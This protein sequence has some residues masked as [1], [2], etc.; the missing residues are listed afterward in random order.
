MMILY[1]QML[2]FIHIGGEGGVARCATSNMIYNHGYNPGE[3]LYKSM[4]SKRFNTIKRKIIF[5][6]WRKRYKQK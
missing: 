4:K 3:N 2:M 1:K 5:S 6:I